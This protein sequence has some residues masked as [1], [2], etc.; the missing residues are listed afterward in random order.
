MWSHVVKQPYSVP[1]E[2]KN[3]SLWFFAPNHVGGMSDTE[4]MCS[5]SRIPL[6]TALASR[7]Q[8]PRSDN[9]ALAGAVNSPQK[10][11]RQRDGRA[12]LFG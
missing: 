5:V 9:A 6:D 7:V 10:G 3:S 4:K 8:R 2:H 11:P 1:P 12:F